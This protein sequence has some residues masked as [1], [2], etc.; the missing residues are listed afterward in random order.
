LSTSAAHTGGRV[1]KYFAI[2]SVLYHFLICSA[3]SSDSQC[4]ARSAGRGQTMEL[5]L[6]G[7]LSGCMATWAPSIDLSARRQ[8]PRRF[9]LVYPLH[10]MENSL[11][12][13]FSHLFTT[14]SHVSVCPEARTG[15]AIGRAGST[16]RPVTSLWEHIF[17]AQPLRSVRCF[18]ASYH[19]FIL[20]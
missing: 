1:R 13:I 8:S 15:A 6:V 20:I 3:P 18:M 19:G 17:M 7:S 14:R 9:P 10:A 16:H 11:Q 5:S 2:F 12:R 4:A